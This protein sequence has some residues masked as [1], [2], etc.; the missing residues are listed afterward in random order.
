M[1]G[2]SLVML[3]VAQCLLIISDPPN[4]LFGYL[5]HKF[6]WEKYNEKN[7]K[8]LIDKYWMNIIN[9]KPAKYERII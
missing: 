7:V 5:L 2:N 3:S 6:M 1:W 9:S 8:R 4:N